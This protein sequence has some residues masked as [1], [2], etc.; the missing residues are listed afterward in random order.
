MS[1]T[2]TLEKGK[3]KES[4]GEFIQHTRE[5]M[6]R[7]SFPSSDEVR[8]TTI[9]VIIGVIFFA[10]FLYLIDIFWGYVLQ[11]IT[12]VFNQLIGA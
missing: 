11:G 5:E 1:E 8:K 9:I 10:I 6:S 4:V 2:A 12:W 7:V 3:K